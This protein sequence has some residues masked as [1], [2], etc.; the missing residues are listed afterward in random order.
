[1]RCIADRIFAAQCYASA[2]NRILSQYLASPRDVN[3][4]VG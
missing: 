1:M 4:A 2:K 3:A